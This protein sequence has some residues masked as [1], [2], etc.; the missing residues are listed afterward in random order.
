MEVCHC[1]LLLG[2]VALDV[3]MGTPCGFLQVLIS[4]FSF[5]QALN[6]VRL[7]S[8]LGVRENVEKENH[9]RIKI[10]VSIQGPLLNP[11]MGGICRE[12]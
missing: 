12:V 7:K 2:D 11:Y 1:R 5:E 10:R 6:N 8:I 9:V 3:T 4:T